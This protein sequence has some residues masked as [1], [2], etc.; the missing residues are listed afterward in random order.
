MSDPSTLPLPPMNVIDASSY[1][2]SDDFK[3]ELSRRF[4]I[5]STPETGHLER[6]PDLDRFFP[7]SRVYRRASDAGGFNVH[8]F[9]DFAAPDPAV[10]DPVPDHLFFAPLPEP[11]PPVLRT[12]RAPA[13]SLLSALQHLDAD[14]RF[15]DD[16]HGSAAPRSLL[17][18]FWVAHHEWV[19]AGA[20]I[21]GALAV[22]LFNSPNQP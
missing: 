9:I 6:A 10:G 4:P 8:Q 11:L 1:V 15:F 19:V 12:D 5:A 13:G 17:A 2:L 21:L 18:S 20:F 14:D 16:L 7:G 22:A 3:A